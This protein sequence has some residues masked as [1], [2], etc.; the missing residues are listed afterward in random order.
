V[1]KTVR[2][3]MRRG[4]IKGAYPVEVR[5]LLSNLDIVTADPW[6]PDILDCYLVSP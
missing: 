2:L 5:H 1:R 6:C 3:A 4:I